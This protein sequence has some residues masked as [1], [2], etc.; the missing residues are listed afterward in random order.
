[1]TIKVMPFD[2]L[3]LGFTPQPWPWAVAKRADIDAYFAE[4]RGKNPALWN[5]RALILHRQ[6]I[7]GSVLRGDYLENDYASYNALNQWGFV[8]PTM[9]DC[10]AQAA[11]KSADG[12][13]LLGV[14]GPQTVHPGE[15]YFPSG[16]PDPTD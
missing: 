3:E 15:I 5:G 6:E 8:D 13:Y 12:A 7:D 9:N 1:M 11:L 14:M 4:L 2:R 10:F 16:T